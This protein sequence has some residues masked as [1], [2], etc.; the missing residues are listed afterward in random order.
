MPNGT[1]ENKLS[2]VS[3]P[4]DMTSEGAGLRIRNPN[5]TTPLF[6]PNAE[7]GLKHDNNCCL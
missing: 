2:T 4:W 7:S 6:L 3:Q 1:A 5:T